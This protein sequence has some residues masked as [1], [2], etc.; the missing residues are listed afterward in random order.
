MLSS[1]RRFVALASSAGCLFAAYMLSRTTSQ[2]PSALRLTLPG[3][4]SLQL[5]S[6]SY[7]LFYAL[8]ALLFL[9]IALVGSGRQKDGRSDRRGNVRFRRLAIVSASTFVLTP[10][11]LI[12]GTMNVPGSFV[13]SV[14]GVVVGLASL[15]ATLTVLI[16]WID[17]QTSIDDDKSI[18]AVVAD[19]MRNVRQSGERGPAE[20]VE[21]Q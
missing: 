12:V 4:A 10:M 1:L 8:A 11:L 2:T 7:S 9:A 18:V 3:G 20:K 14:W 15:P 5:E 17:G 21:G 6:A 19:Q 16:K 13:F